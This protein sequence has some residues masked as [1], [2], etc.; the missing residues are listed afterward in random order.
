MWRR[1]QAGEAGR[2][3]E[4]PEVG[5]DRPESALARA[6]PRLTAA[7]IEASECLGQAADL[8]RVADIRPHADGFPGEKRLQAWHPLGRVIER[9]MEHNGHGSNILTAPGAAQARLR[10]RWQRGFNQSELLARLTA[11]R[12]CSGMGTTRSNC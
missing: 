4:V 12:Q 5:L 11:R 7:Q 3:L 9:G 6:R 1:A 10:R 8:Y 2:C